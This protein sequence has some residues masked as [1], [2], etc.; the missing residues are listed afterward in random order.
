[1]GGDNNTCTID[2]Y[3]CCMIHYI[4]SQCSQMMRNLQNIQTMFASTDYTPSLIHT[5]PL[6]HTHHTIHIDN[7]WYRVALV[8]DCQFYVQR[9]LTRLL[10]TSDFHLPCLLLVNSLSGTSALDTAVAPPVHPKQVR[11]HV[12]FSSNN[13]L[14]LES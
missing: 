6:P 14:S 9:K 7:S 2:T 13:Y 5:T 3:T 8:H 1:M 4:N 12:E 10:E 11:V